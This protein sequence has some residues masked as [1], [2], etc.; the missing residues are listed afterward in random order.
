M[1][2]TAV[3]IRALLSTWVLTGILA[4][5]AFTLLSL[6]SNQRLADNTQSLLQNTQP[7]EQ[8]NYFALLMLNQFIN[9]QNHIFSAQTL[10]QLQQWQRSS[11]TQSHYQAALQAYQQAAQLNPQLADYLPQFEELYGYFKD[12]AEQLAELKQEN[13]LLAAEGYNHLAKVR[14]SI[15][16]GEQLVQQVATDAALP[17][18]I[19]NHLRL[20]LANLAYQ[21]AQLHFAD[22]E[23]RLTQYQQ[24]LSQLLTDTRE[25]VSPFSTLAA[26]DPLLTNIEQVLLQ[27]NNA[28]LELG[29]N[30]LANQEILSEVQE[31]VLEDQQALDNTLAS[32]RSIAQQYRQ[33][34]QQQILAI[35]Q[36]SQQHQL[37][38]A[39]LV[40]S[41][42]LILGLTIG[43]RITHSLSQL[44]QLLTQLAQGRL[45]LKIEQG[46][47]DEFGL[48]FQHIEAM[49]CHWRQA[50][51]QI[52][53]ATQQISH[54]S[55]QLSHVSHN[56]Q[57]GADQQESQVQQINHTLEQLVIQA[58]HAERDAQD[59][60]SAAEQ[61]RSIADAGAKTILTNVDAINTLS[62]QVHS[63]AASIHNLNQHSE[64][65]TDILDVINAIAEQTNLLALNAAIEAAR[66]GSH[67]Q[68]FAVVA[69]EV[70][71]LA[72]RT[73]D[74]TTEIQSMLEGLAKE[75]QAAAQ[76]M[77][78]S[79]NQA[80]QSAKHN[81]TT[82]D[83]LNSI[84]H[85]AQ[86]I[87]MTNT[88]VVTRSQQQT[89]LA[90]TINQNMLKITQVISN[91][92][93]GIG[94]MVDANQTLSQLAPELDQ[95]T[96]KFQL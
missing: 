18:P 58:E 31:Q 39:A 38:A 14:D 50:L 71:T 59:A 42:M 79:R 26:L 94:Y 1:R 74:A 88:E 75:A 5:A 87:V 68:G 70:R 12:S 96:Q 72:K 36:Q 19:L 51:G 6:S 15:A 8:G 76:T 78:D 93:T 83:I 28:V 77:S 43:R 90:A 56:A 11:Q 9:Q 34:S 89:E 4:A 53:T 7:I 91:T 45:D 80:S 62:D 22:S 3:S 64:Q 41:L 16:Q 69:D 21:G 61:A 82:R 48:L 17:T 86:S 32:F 10:E 2:M 49:L 66:A 65:I 81:A 35:T 33:T 57:Q 23:T 52:S 84:T 46:R 30:R 37:I 47:K 85:A 73:Q 44:G 20:Q 13:M 40:I 25:H 92:N 54:T 24:S 95:L 60:Q 55:Q 27:Q 29:H 67:G 63:A